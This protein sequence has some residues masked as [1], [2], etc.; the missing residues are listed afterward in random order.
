MVRGIR[1]GAHRALAPFLRCEFDYAALEFMLSTLV[2]AVN[3]LLI[4]SPWRAHVC[5]KARRRK[6]GR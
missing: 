1:C 5:L 4:R 3:V 2:A 6:R